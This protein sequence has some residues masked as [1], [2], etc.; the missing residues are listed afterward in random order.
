MEG[1][2][3][4]GGMFYSAAG[5]KPIGAQTATALGDFWLNKARATLAEKQIE[6][7]PKRVAIQSKAA[8]IEQGTLNYKVR[9]TRLRMIGQIIKN[10]GLLIKN[11]LR[12]IGI[13]MKDLSPYLALALVIMVVFMGW[14]FGPPKIRRGTT[15]NKS[16]NLYNA[17]KTRWQRFKSWIGGL[18]AMI[19]PGHQWKTFLRML[20]PLAG[21]FTK[22]PRPRMIYGRCDQVT[23][24]ELGGDGR[25][26]LCARTYAPKDIN[27]VMDTE[28]MPDMNRMPEEM[29]QKVTK[30]GR[31]LQV[32][33]PWALQGTFY[34]PQCS[35]AVFGDGASA[36]GLFKDEG[37]TCRKKEVTVPTYNERYRVKG[38]T[39]DAYTSER[40]PK[41]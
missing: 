41:C 27:W 10:I 29:Y 12:P 22:L 40:D 3:D 33:I 35:K 28:K 6:E 13:I 34:V 18:F 16:N 17:A 4:G 2:R 25:A 19:T 8:A 24:R 14:K 1:L 32:T 7:I 26:G 15:N 36:A 38:G 20:N 21:S 5:G 11:M 23:W 31:R 39:V 37:M 30:D 9:S